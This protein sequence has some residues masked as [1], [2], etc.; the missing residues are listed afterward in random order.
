[1]RRYVK[2]MEGQREVLELTASQEFSI[3]IP[4]KEADQIH[5]GMLLRLWSQ[6]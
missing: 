6:E 4:D 1:L 2:K 3:E 5:S